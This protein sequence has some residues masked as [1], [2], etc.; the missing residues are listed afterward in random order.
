MFKTEITWYNPVT[1][2]YPDTN[3]QV[4]GI[5]VWGENGIPK[6]DI[7]PTYFVAKNNEWANVDCGEIVLFWTEKN[8]M[9]TNF[10]GEDVKE[11]I[12]KAF[13]KELMVVP[14]NEISNV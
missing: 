7:I 11:L 12:L 9:L 14:T 13:Q 3:R 2:G 6:F 10:N 4:M 5:I 8:P 1:D